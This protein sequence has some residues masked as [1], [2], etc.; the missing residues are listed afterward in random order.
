MRDELQIVLAVK[1]FPPDM[2][3]GLELAITLPRDRIERMSMGELQEI[4]RNALRRPG[5]QNLLCNLVHGK[6]AKRPPGGVFRIEK[7]RRKT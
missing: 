7:P 4:L 1:A 3:P 6:A 5:S 2:T